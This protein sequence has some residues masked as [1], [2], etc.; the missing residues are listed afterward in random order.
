VKVAL[1]DGVGNVAVHETPEKAPVV[2]DVGRHAFVRTGE[3][4][5]NLPVYRVR[6]GGRKGD[7]PAIRENTLNRY[8]AEA[9]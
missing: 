3:L 7:R 4:V 6:L 1:V 2:L 8:T 9:A 5:K